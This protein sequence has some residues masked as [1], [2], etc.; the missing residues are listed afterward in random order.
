MAF[1]TLQ[2]APFNNSQL[3]P[4]G[5]LWYLGQG[6]GWGS[7]EGQRQDPTIPELS[8]PISSSSKKKKKKRRKPSRRRKEKEKKKT[9]VAKKEMTD[10]I[11]VTHSNVLFTLLT[12]YFIYKLSYLVSKSQKMKNCKWERRNE[13]ASKRYS[14]NKDQ[15]VE[16]AWQQI[17]GENRLWKADKKLKKCISAR[18]LGTGGIT[19]RKG[20][21]TTYLCIPTGFENTATLTTQ[22]KHLHLKWW[23][24]VIRIKLYF[25]YSAW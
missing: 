8:S 5:S 23:Y 21:D 12:I 3:I 20:K 4:S 25:R 6:H 1:W 19:Q 24:R 2:V 11:Y 9:A 14:Q 18:S 7:R 22:Y 16:K 15:I 13:P 10:S 17:S